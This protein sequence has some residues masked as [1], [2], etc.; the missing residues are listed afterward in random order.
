MIDQFLESIHPF[1]MVLPIAA[2][3][4][5]WCLTTFS[6]KEDWRVGF[7]KAALAWGAITLLMTELLSIFAAIHPTTLAVGW[8][9]VITASVCLIRRHTVEEREGLMMVAKRIFTFPPEDRWWIAPLI[10][11]GMIA[12]TTLAIALIAPPNNWDS[13][14]YHMSRVE[15][16]R[17]NASVAHY[18]TNVVWQLFLNP[19]AEFAILQFQTLGFGSDRL[20]N[21]VQWFA[22]VG[23][24]VGVSLLL[25]LLGGSIFSQSLAAFV[26][27]TTPMVILQSTSTQN[28]VVCGFFVVAAI[29]F[30]FERLTNSSTKLEIYFPLSV[31]L[32]V[33]TKATAY[34]ILFPFVAYSLISVLRQDGLKQGVRLAGVL[35]LALL[36]LNAGHW[37]RNF[38]LWQHPLGDPERLV[39]Y[40][41]ESF[42]MP[43]TVSNVVRNVALH[44]GTPSSRVNASIEAG[45]QKIHGMLGISIGEP[46]LTYGHPNQIVPEPRWLTHE[47]YAGN[48]LALVLSF[49]AAGFAILTQ[50]GRIRHFG[51]LLLMSSL[52]FCLSLKWAPFNSR[53]HTPLFLLSAA[54]VGWVLAPRQLEVSNVKR[55]WEKN[56]AV[57]VGIGLTASGIILNEWVVARLFSPG[58]TIHSGPLRLGI[59]VLDVAAIVSGILALVWKGLY[60][61]IVTG[62]VILLLLLGAFPWIALNQLR[63]LI[64]TEYAPSIFDRTRIDLMFANKNTLSVPYTALVSMLGQRTSCRE[65]GLKLG[66]EDFEY[67]LWQIAR[68]AGVD[69]VFRHVG[70][71]NK[72]AGI[73]YGTPRKSPCAVVVIGDEKQGDSD[74]SG[75][76]N[77][78]AAWSLAS[79][80]LLV[81]TPPD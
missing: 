13:M 19:W 3:V 16:W 45:V 62:F 43:E 11:V 74:L 76:G 65:I 14:T 35:M 31:A 59:W 23:S 48:G 80:R 18:P 44:L 66:I 28:D 40:K 4:C 68:S 36:V 9:I 24:L 7:L 53:L 26:V 69:V 64:S 73:E 30:A 49:G 1:L 79:I 12:L 61:R 57:L 10:P 52:C 75:L 21:S 81:P 33:A 22:F 37:A 70:V 27:A 15:H 51:L 42:G 41:N 39:K 46:S 56:V 77:M 20:A 2:F 17:A 5:L 63:P 47:D 50:R 6:Q 8:I 58:G 32:A 55:V 78:H 25:R 38:D 67:P 34:P 60:L 29:Y 71:T 72:S 54:I